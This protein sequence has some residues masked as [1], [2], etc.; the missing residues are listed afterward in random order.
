MSAAFPLPPAKPE[1]AVIC[2]GHAVLDHIFTVPHLPN[3]EGKHFATGYQS[4]GGGPA[5]TAA[6]TV[7]RLGGL[8]RLW[9]RL[10]ADEIGDRIIADLT[11]DNVGT[12]EVRRIAGATSS[13]SA[14]MVDPAGERMIVNHLDPALSTDPHWL[15]VGDLV[16]DSVGAVLGDL[17]WPDGTAHA[18]AAARAV[19]IPAVLDADTIPTPITS[20][21]YQAASHILFSRPGLAQ[22]TGAETV[23]QGLHIASDTTDALVAVT[24]GGDGVRWLENGQARHLPAF[25]VAVKDT[26]GAGD[27]FHGAFALALARRLPVHDAFRFAAGAA[28]LKCTRPG[29]RAGIPTAAA[30]TAFLDPL[31]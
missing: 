3:A 11:T 29:G 24:E 27:V 8:V 19:G 31:T 30:L 4:V 18:L 7:A 10:G 9:A 23:E 2:V 22:Y 6:V 14:V 17:R 15:P 16:P 5:A 21:P 1:P 12:D 20:A 25:P 28:A 13:L 26:V